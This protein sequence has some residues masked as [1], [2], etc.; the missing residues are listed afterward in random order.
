MHYKQHIQGIL[1]HGRNLTLYRSFNNISNG[2]NLAIHTWLLNLEEVYL[3]EGKLPDIIFVQ[4]D[5][6]SENANVTMKGICELMVSR[7]LTKKIVLT[8]LPK[9][10][11]HEDIDAVFGN[12]W[13]YI[14][15]KSVI[16]PQAYARALEHGL[17]KRNEKVYV[18]DIFCVPDYQNWMKAYI[19][20]ALSRC[21]KLEWTAL[22]WIFEN[23]G[24][25]THGCN[26]ENCK[27]YPT[28]VKVNYRKFASDEVILVSED[29]T[30]ALGFDHKKCK[31]QTHPT[32]EKEGDPDGMFI[33][34][35]LPDGTREFLP[36]PFIEGSRKHLETLVRRLTS[37]FGSLPCVRYEWEHWRDHVAPLTDNANDYC[38]SFPLHIPFWEQMFSASPIDATQ[39]INPRVP[40]PRH[41]ESPLFETTNS[42]VWSNRGKPCECVMF[43]DSDIVIRLL[44]FQVNL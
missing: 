4:I 32:P 25:C 21:D 39:H 36:Q 22:Q 13:K 19:D 38:N 41:D 12:I 33:L 28:G 9:G 31:V 2:S 37:E 29:S 16:T 44:I 15:S 30:T 27:L 3:R 24:D 43:V 34:R 7:H 42:V 35:S 23:I 17:K 14:E 18:K 20:P 26:C 40:K 5:G 1:N 6:G 8:R 11:T 10:H